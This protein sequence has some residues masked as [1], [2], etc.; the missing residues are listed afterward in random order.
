MSG[1]ESYLILMVKNGVK[2]VNAVNGGV[3]HPAVLIF[4]VDCVRW[5]L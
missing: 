5:F 4:F 1:G 2:W 3:R